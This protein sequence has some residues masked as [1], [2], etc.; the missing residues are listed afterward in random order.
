MWPERDPR[1]FSPEE[2]RRWQLAARLLVAGAL[3]ALVG[4][5]IAGWG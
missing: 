4:G 5:L 3:L 1:Q 2:Y